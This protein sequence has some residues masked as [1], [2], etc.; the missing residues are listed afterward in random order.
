MSAC[1]YEYVCVRVR[2]FLCVRG[3]VRACVCVCVCV[4]VCVITCVLCSASMLLA[5]GFV[6]GNI[7]HG[8]SL[9]EY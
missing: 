3:F 1:V 4:R 5:S 9:P 2:A 7:S 6:E 8:L